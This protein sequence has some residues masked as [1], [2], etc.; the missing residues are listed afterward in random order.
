QI[1]AQS[2]QVQVSTS[3]AVAE[4]VGEDE[5][6]HPPAAAAATPA[7]PAAKAAPPMDDD[8]A[9]ADMATLQRLLADHAAYIK[10]DASIEDR[11]LFRQLRDA[12]KEAGYRFDGN[13]QSWFLPQAA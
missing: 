6:T 10:L 4:I 11:T 12:L 1:M 2:E 9:V 7:E 13:N 8:E 3:M 5:E